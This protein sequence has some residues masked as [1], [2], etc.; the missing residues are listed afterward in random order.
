[1]ELDLV[2]YHKGEP[3]SPKGAQSPKVK[4]RKTVAGGAGGGLKGVTTKGVSRRTTA[5]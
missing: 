3:Q 2:A 4:K 5:M 1:M